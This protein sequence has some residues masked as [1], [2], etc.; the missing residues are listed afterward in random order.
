VSD[1][2]L[3]HALTSKDSVKSAATYFGED[4][5]S[6]INDIGAGKIPQQQ[7]QYFDASLTMSMGC[8]G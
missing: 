6:R 8:P 5:A 1:E 4:I 7:S 2:T 3:K